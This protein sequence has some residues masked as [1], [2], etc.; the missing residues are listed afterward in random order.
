MYCIYVIHFTGIAGV[1]N[2]FTQ[3]DMLDKV[4]LTFKE[5]RAA[6]NLYYENIS[7]ILTDCVGCKRGES[8]VGG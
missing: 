6:K 5:K 4:Y 2:C 8:G 1:V 7:F 3:S